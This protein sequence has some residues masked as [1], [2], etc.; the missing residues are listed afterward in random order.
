MG[1]VVLL[2]PSAGFT[3]PQGINQLT[4]VLSFR[5]AHPCSSGSHTD[6]KVSSDRSGQF[7]GYG[8]QPVHKCCKTARALATEGLITRKLTHYR[9]DVAFGSFQRQRPR[10][11]LL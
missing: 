8:L 6:T 7:E 5:R 4:L 1:S 11:A 3:G 2:Y 10:P 9:S